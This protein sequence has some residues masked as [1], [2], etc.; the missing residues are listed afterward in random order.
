MPEDLSQQ[1]HDAHATAEPDHAAPRKSA[2]AGAFY[3]HALAW[4]LVA[5]LP[6]AVCCTAIWNSIR[7]RCDGHFVFSLD[8]PYIHLAL[9]ESIAHGHYGINLDA[10][11][12]PSSSVI[13]PFLLAPLAHYNTPLTALAL[14]LLF[15]VGAILLIGVC[16]AS[17]VRGSSPPEDGARRMFAAVS[18]VFI[19][20]LPALV[21]VGME[22]TLQV[23]LSGIVAWG[24]IRALDRRPIPAVSILAAIVLPSVRY[25]GLAITLALALALYIQRRSAAAALTLLLSLLPL[26]AFS[27]YLHHLGLPLLPTSVIVKSG[28]LQGGIASRLVSAVINALLESAHFS[29]TVI[30]LATL[31]LA[32]RATTRERRLLLCAAA[33]AEFLHLAIGPFGWFHRY[34][35]AIEFFAMLVL[36]P[37]LFRA[38]KVPLWAFCLAMLPLAI[39]GLYYVPRTPIAAAATYRQQFQAHRFITQIVSGNVAVNDL[40]LVSYQRRPGQEI[41]DVYGLGSPEAAAARIKDAAWMQSITE[42]HQ[43]SWTIVYSDFYGNAIPATWRHLGAVCIRLGEDVMV[44]DPCADYYSTPLVPASDADQAFARFA[45]TLPPDRVTAYPTH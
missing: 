27:L 37:D 6:F 19:A 9:A 13:W 8:D 14:N 16:I 39:S 1:D 3:L 26:A 30:L 15:A 25:E 22:H 17:L 44:N 40:G 43:V 31:Y 2:R 12:S 36:L 4:S 42:R 21:F 38:D 28:G 45:A 33:F 5:S 24:F 11:S 18:L 7:A 34:E 35:V 32:R 20:S 10:P 23:L 41:V 29:L